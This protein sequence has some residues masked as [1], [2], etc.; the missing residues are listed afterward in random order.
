MTQEPRF[1]FPGFSFREA[2]DTATHQVEVGTIQDGGVTYLV[3]MIRNKQFDFLRFGVSQIRDSNE[4]DL[5]LYALGGIDGFATLANANSQTVMAIIGKGKYGKLERVIP[6][7][8]LTNHTPINIRS[9]IRLKHAA[10]AFLGMDY[11]LTNSEATVDRLDRER[12]AVRKLEAFR[13]EA[14]ERATAR[15]RR[16]RELL[17][18]GQ[19]TGYTIDGTARHG[20]PVL[21]SEWMSCSNGTSVVI[22]ESISE[23]GTIG[24]PREA[25][26]V[27]KER[28]KDPKK[29][30]S[31]F[32]TAK[33]PT[34]DTINQIVRPVGSVVIE[35]DD[36]ALE[37]HLYSSMEVIREAQKKGLNG[38]T[39]VAV[40]G[41]DHGGKIQVFAVH[42]DG[43]RTLG[44]FAPLI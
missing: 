8:S 13:A 38:G 36:D 23:D 3:T 30:F 42:H 37:V 33:K 6:L 28:G 19:V 11:V 29:G 26:K 34:I 17:T 39:L 9:L 12:E 40:K 24:A 16:V 44:N 20:I 22:V 15:E 27:V 1:Q 18:R 4:R 41:R 10:A 35:K 14:A 31:A 32:V 5:W 25:F 2:Q 21:E 43:I 7:S